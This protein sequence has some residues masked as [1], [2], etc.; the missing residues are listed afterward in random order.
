MRE[1]EL[2]NWKTAAEVMAL[3]WLARKMHLLPNGELLRREREEAEE[4]RIRAQEERAE[5]LSRPRS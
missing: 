3:R 5:R 4:R 1:S 2:D